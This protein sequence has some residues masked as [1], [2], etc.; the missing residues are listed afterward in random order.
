M[1]LGLGIHG[2]IGAGGRASL[3]PL[4]SVIERMLYQINK[5]KCCYSSISLL[6]LYFSTKNSSP[7]F[8]Y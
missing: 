3:E 7:V 6:I 1:E 4:H 2:E 5:G 8:V